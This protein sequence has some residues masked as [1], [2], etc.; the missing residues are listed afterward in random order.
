MAQRPAA[1]SRV[2]G[3][4][5][6]PRDCHAGLPTMTS[7]GRSSPSSM[8]TTPRNGSSS[9]PWRITTSAPPWR[10]VFQ[11]AACSTDWSR[12]SRST[13]N[14]ERATPAAARAAAPMSACGIPACARVPLTRSSSVTWRA[15]R[16]TGSA[17]GPAAACRRA[18]VEPNRRRT[19]SPV[20]KAGRR[21]R[22]A[23][24]PVR[25]ERRAA[26]PARGRECWRAGCLRPMSWHQYS[27]GP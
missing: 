3:P 4:S 25:C 11:N 2:A 15:L 8:R 23:P 7:T 19:R 17:C 27:G 6:V 20:Q 21:R 26:W 12:T 24:A 1:R 18:A 5:R 14:V 9:S 16:C 22:R 13:S 10:S